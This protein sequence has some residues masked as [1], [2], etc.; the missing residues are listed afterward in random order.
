MHKE[1]CHPFREMKITVNK[2][3]EKKKDEK[4]DL[5][6]FL[7]NPNLLKLPY[8]SLGFCIDLESAIRV[9]SKE[10]DR[11]EYT[12]DLKIDDPTKFTLKEKFFDM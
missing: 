1:I 11:F 9:V 6:K 7:E 10:N 4:D 8:Q 5:Q 2:L 12:Y 3:K